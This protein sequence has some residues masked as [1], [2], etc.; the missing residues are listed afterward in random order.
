[1]MIGVANGIWRPPAADRPSALLALL[2]FVVAFPHFVRR[3]APFKSLNS[4]ILGWLTG[5]E[6]ALREPQS[7]VLPLHYSHREILLSV[8]DQIEKIPL[9]IFYFNDLVSEAYQHNKIRNKRRIYFLVHIF[10]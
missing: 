1:M 3:K 10:S 2:L 7:L 4:K 8:K 6:P 5:F 9:K